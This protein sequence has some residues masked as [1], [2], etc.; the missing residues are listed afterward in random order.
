M[1]NLPKKVKFQ[2]VHTAFDV[3]K[4][5]PAFKQTPEW[6]RK[7]SGVEEKIMTIKK[8]IPFLDAMTSGYVICSPVDVN[9]NGNEFSDLSKVR[10][11][12]AHH[13]EQTA[14]LPVPRGFSSQP[15]KWENFFT[16]TTPKGYSTLFVHP[17][18][19]HDLPFS[20]I[21]GVVDTDSHPLPVNFPFFIEEGFTGTIPAGTPII[22]A[23]PFKRESWVSEVED[24]IPPKEI[25]DAY[26]MHH[27]P[28]GFYKKH[29]W[30][31]KSY[32]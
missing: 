11:V 18:N 32:K 13:K 31:K 19:R 12:S 9:F 14:D 3:P 28:F 29:W 16:M 4:P 21:T 27:P 8:C 20:C 1:L 23:I 25:L 7:M 10:V 26:K 17:V 5:T 15:Y 24:N 6:Y 2:S 30:H 22:Q